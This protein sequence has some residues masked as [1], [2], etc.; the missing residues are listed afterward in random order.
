MGCGGG[1]DEGVTVSPN[2]DL[3]HVEVSPIAV[4]QFE[5]V[6]DL[7]RRSYVVARGSFVGGPEVISQSGAGEELVSSN[8][9][10]EF[11]PSEVF[12]DVRDRASEPA[13]AE[14]ERG[15]ILVAATGNEI[16]QM[17]GDQTLPEFV[18]SFHS[19][20]NLNSIVLDKEVYVFLQRGAF[21][22]DV[23]AARPDLAHVMGIVGV[24]QCYQVADLDHTCTYAAD[25]P[26]AAAEAVLESRALAPDDLSVP[27]I[28]GAATV[29]EVEA[30]LPDGT[31]DPAVD[32][33]RFEIVDTAGG[34]G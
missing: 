23:V 22:E 21:G 33:D 31:P 2:R 25:E 9:V 15:S 1:S 30:V 10:W 7:I 16:G 26:G 32:T 20:Y 12:R 13:R 27:V 3:P 19:I 5:S 4:E 18:Q 17:R 24:T 14:A 34:E 11:V 28:E 8:L 6:E 29:T